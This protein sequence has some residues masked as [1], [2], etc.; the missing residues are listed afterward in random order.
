MHSALHEVVSFM[1]FVTVLKISIHT[2][3]DLTAATEQM[4]RIVMLY[5]L[6]QS[7]VCDYI[8]KCLNLTVICSLKL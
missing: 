6:C 2:L 3:Q 1:L 5:V 4:H 7:A 8:M